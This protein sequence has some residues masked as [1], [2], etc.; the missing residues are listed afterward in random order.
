MGLFAV[1]ITFL[2]E[3]LLDRAALAAEN[4]ALRRQLSVLQRSAKRPQLRR[5][6]RIF[7]VWLSPLWK[8]RRSNLMI[9]KPETVIRWHWHGFRLYWRWKSSK[10]GRPKTDA[11]IRMLIRRMSRGN[12]IWGVPRITSGVS[13]PIT[14]N[15]TTAR[16]RT[17]HL[18]GTRRSRERLS[19]HILAR[20]SPSHTWAGCTT[21]TGALPDPLS[22]SS[23]THVGPRRRSVARGPIQ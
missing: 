17:F 18:S 8:N 6:D 23:R 13:W 10:G 16:G 22:E 21:V 11:E 2:R 7:W 9:V 5:G 14:S 19:R 20:L 15:A 1:F 3:Y 12:P 4:L